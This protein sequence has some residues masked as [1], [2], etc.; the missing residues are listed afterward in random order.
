[1]PHNIIKKPLTILL[2]CF[3]ANLVA[4]KTNK[5]ISKGIFGKTN[6]TTVAKKEL[7]NPV[8]QQYKLPPEEREKEGDEAERNYPVNMSAVKPFNAKL[9]VIASPL[10]SNAP[11]GIQEFPCNNFKAL[12]NSQTISPPDVNGAAGF[13]H[14]MVTLNS[15]V[16][17]QNKQGAQ[18]DVNTLQGF[19]NGLG[20]HNDIYDPKI[21]YDPYDKR[22]F[23]ICCADRIS[24]TS[25]L[26]LGVSQTPDP[27]GGWNT[28]TI[29]ADPGSL[30]WFDYPSV[31]FN[32][33]W[34]TVGGNMF[35]MTDTSFSNS[36]M[37]VIN[38][39]DVYAGL[40]NINVPFFD[41]TEF[42]IVPAVTYDAFDNTVWCVT[43]ANSNL[44]NN[45]IVRLF[46]ITGTGA[47]PNFNVGSDVNVGPA[48]AVAGV[49][50]PQSGSAT[51]LDLGD[52]RILQTTFRNGT[53]WF[54][55]NVFL[56]AANP[57]TCAA[58]IISI[59]PLSGTALENIKTTVD[60][61]GATM[62]AYPS[63]TV[64]Q[65]N[66]IFFGCS[67]FR[68]TAFP[69]STILY[70]RANQGFFIYYYKSGEDWYVNLVRGVN[71]WGDYSATYIDPEDNTTAWTIQEYARPKA[72]G[73][74]GVWGT[75]WAKVCPGFCLND[76]TL[77]DPM[78]NVMQKFEANLTITSTAQIQSNSTIK[79]D[80]G[81]RV[82]LSPGFKAAEGSKVKIYIEGCGG[83]Q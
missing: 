49:N 70:R 50:G 16:R 82:T 39:A 51:G 21:M 66:D 57:T 54:G 45:G 22:W 34:I 61:T 27:T 72:V 26:L 68:T 75:W 11:Q 62:N 56:P 58:Q 42:T 9:T 78:N 24:T 63:I 53:L 28:Y 8:K 10:S 43:R 35:T 37:W 25:A 33:N 3:S 74:L 71:R 41:R 64:N 2:I 47:A 36:R 20:G 81:S 4:Q 30:L 15:D 44:N 67:T 6:F 18:I 14:L 52:D 73:N 46:S 69:T 79:Y 7:S 5:G 13:D 31:G 65:N 77:S 59:D 19:W 83:V 17:I 29:K 12:D 76:L 23:F 38:K 48:W 1:M 55:N 60:N 40:N 80:A 32:R